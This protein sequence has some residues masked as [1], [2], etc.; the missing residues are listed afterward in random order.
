M[1]GARVRGGATDYVLSYIFSPV[2]SYQ[3]KHLTPLLSC[4]L[5]F[6]QLLLFNQ[7]VMKKTNHTFVVWL[8]TSRDLL[9]Q[10]PCTDL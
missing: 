1:R 2:L 4:R 10:R 6:D 3:I 5:S 7:V 9:H 8:L